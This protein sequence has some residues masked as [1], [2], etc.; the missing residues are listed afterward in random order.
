MTYIDHYIIHIKRMTA[1]L[2]LSTILYSCAPQVKTPVGKLPQPKSPAL[3]LPMEKLHEQEAPAV[4]QCINGY[5][6]LDYP[7]ELTYAWDVVNEALAILELGLS[8]SY[9]GR[10]EGSIHA[11]RTDGDKISI[12]L[13][14]LTEKT[15][16]IAIKSTKFSSCESVR[17]IQKEIEAVSGL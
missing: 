16:S 7:F 2:L 10:N 12:K 11:V 6:S 17:Q 8:Y 3:E 14:Q 13:K 15:T 5:L 9:M 1:L 4:D